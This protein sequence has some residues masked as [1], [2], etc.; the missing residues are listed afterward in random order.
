M[1]N[2]QLSNWV[3]SW[4]YHPINLTPTCNIPS[5]SNGLS[6]A[7][8]PFITDLSMS[9]GNDC[10]C[11]NLTILFSASVTS[12]TDKGV[13]LSFNCIFELVLL[14]ACDFGCVSLWKPRI[15]HATNLRSRSH[16]KQRWNR[17]L[18]TLH[19]FSCIPLDF[20]LILNFCE[21]KGSFLKVWG[22]LSSVSLLLWSPVRFLGL[23][24]WSASP[25]CN[26]TLT[27]VFMD[28]QVMTPFL[29][30]CQGIL[31]NII[32]SSSNLCCSSGEGLNKSLSLLSWKEGPAEGSEGRRL[33]QVLGQ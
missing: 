7:S 31:G 8:W 12:D 10:L 24:L 23:K 16:L 11:T 14:S 19:D 28:A 1:K 13:V 6:R 21:T 18:Q 9:I 27:A 15:S 26:K 33:A 25:Y 5:S 4:Q 32:D 2:Y 29:K 20:I 22:G 3:F 30:I 17:E